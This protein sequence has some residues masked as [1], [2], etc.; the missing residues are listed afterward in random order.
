MTKL[1]R[2][3][4]LLLDHRSFISLGIEPHLVLKGDDVVCQRQRVWHRGKGKC[5]VCKREINVLDSWEMDHKQGGTVGRCD[6]LHNLQVSCWDCHRKKH[7][8]PQFTQ[9]KAEA[10]KTFDQLYPETA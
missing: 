9:R 1:L 6:C 7:V 10:V 4:G 5:A 3:N 8:R 2:A